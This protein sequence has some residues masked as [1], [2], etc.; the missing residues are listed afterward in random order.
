MTHKRAIRIDTSIDGS[1]ESGEPAPVGLDAHHALHKQ[2]AM[3]LNDAIISA[4]CDLYSRGF[5]HKEIC[6][7]LNIPARTFY[8]WLERGRG[9]KQPYRRLVEGLEACKVQRWRHLLGIIEQ[10]A[11]KTWT[12]AAWLLERECPERWASPEVRA[13]LGLDTEPVEIA[14]E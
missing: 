12:A 10:A 7:A 11:V 4:A 5:T 9:G 2:T 1:P 14:D 13:R 3:R 6:A 8:S